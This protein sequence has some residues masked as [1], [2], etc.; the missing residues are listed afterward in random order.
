MS[1]NAT[2]PPDQ[3]FTLETSSQKAQPKSS[4]PSEELAKEVLFSQ[5]GPIF[6][7]E[8]LQKEF[9]LSTPSDTTS[10]IISKTG[11]E[12]L[13]QKKV[14]KFNPL[15]T[16][17]I[18]TRL[19]EFSGSPKEQAEALIQSRFKEISHSFSFQEKDISTFYLLKSLNLQ[20]PNVFIGSTSKKQLL[21]KDANFLEADFILH[22]TEKF[23]I[24][25]FK[26]KERI[27]NLKQLLANEH[28]I[29]L[30]EFKAHYVEESSW[31]VFT[32]FLDETKRIRAEAIF[33]EETIPKERRVEKH[34]EEPFTKNIGLEIPLSFRKKHP[35]KNKGAEIHEPN[36]EGDKE[37]VERQKDEEKYKKEREKTKDEIHLRKEEK[38]LKYQQGKSEIE[39]KEKG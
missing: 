10:Q 21:N 13:L 23:I 34:T 39:E 24:A 37:V 4:S 33:L 11:S 25:P 32:Q 19:K 5:E 26:Y 8:S 9:S 31:Q 20:N 18:Q 7:K 16:Q 28:K 36:R 14:V 1:L 29:D 15:D 12:I 3:K 27:E 22:K 17:N 38:W 6:S 35:S 30:S 2:P